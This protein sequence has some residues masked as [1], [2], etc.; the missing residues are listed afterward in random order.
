MLTTIV[1][2][3]VETV[4]IVSLFGFVVWCFFHS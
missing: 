1:I 2:I 3:V 4:L